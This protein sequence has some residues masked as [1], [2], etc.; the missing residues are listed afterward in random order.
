M[1][2]GE[3]LTL[4][5]PWRVLYFASAAGA[6]VVGVI[7][8]IADA[9][10]TEGVEIK[11][12]SYIAPLSFPLFW[13]VALAMFLSTGT[14]AGFTF[15]T[16]SFISDYHAAIPRLSG[17]GTAI[18]A[19][20]MAAGRLL[21]GRLSHRFSMR[22]ILLVSSFGG[23]AA[24]VLVIYAGGVVP[25]FFLLAAVGLIVSGFWPS[26]LAIASRRLPC[27]TTTMFILIVSSGMGG[28][29]VTPYLIGTLGDR[30]GLKGGL[31]ILP[32]LF[33]GTAVLLLV[34]KNVSNRV[35]SHGR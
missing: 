4:G 26:L 7:F 22:N 13:I 27:E 1:I 19:G 32:V 18:F 16:A 35:P 12:G 33:L 9:A 14:E 5:V 15:W 3:L 28:F 2:F 21:I 30:W 17:I 6:L 24:S 10:F 23:I 34:M 8:L 11:Q 29:G 25:V 31:L 20:S